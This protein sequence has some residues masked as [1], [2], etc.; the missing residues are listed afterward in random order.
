MYN[1]QIFCPAQ[2]LSSE[3]LN[4]CD[5]SMSKLIRAAQ[6]TASRTG[7]RGSVDFIPLLQAQN[8][9]KK[10]TEKHPGNLFSTPCT[11]KTKSF[12]N[13]IFFSSKLLNK[14]C[15]PG[16][17]AKNLA[18]FVTNNNCNTFKILETSPDPFKVFS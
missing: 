4:P 13:T 5:K 12:K 7:F 10:G 8:A 14:L 9:I 2:L 17:L 16:I 3:G 11:Y 6:L 18:L 1:V 15:F